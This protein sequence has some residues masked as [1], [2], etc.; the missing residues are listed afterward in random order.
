MGKRTEE[1]EKLKTA[2]ENFISR[3]H[4]GSLE[5]IYTK[6]FDFLHN[7]GRKFR[8]DNELI[9]DAIQNTFVN[10]IGARER[11]KN[12]RNLPSYI[13][14]SFRYELL[15]LLSDSKKTT[16]GDIDA[17]HIIEPQSNREEQIISEESD[18][19][20]K[21]RLVRCIGNL[22]PSQ[23][24]IIYLRFTSGLTYEQ[25][26]ESVEISVESCRTAVYRALKAIKNNISTTDN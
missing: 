15:R 26:S 2:C 8:C 11:L 7:Y 25:I 12:V 3:G 1:I 20:L 16:S 18:A 13:L 14:H 4:I 6:Y 22:P 21:E 10:L 17:F 9:E 24:E 23:Q 19:S 5:V